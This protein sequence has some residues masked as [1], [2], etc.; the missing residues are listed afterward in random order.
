MI[1][2]IK[3]VLLFLT[4]TEKKKITCLVFGFIFSGVLEAFG[5][6]I[7]MPFVSIVNDPELLSSYPGVFAFFSWLGI[8]EH[9]STIIILALGILVLFSVKNLYLFFF[10]RF[11]YRFMHYNTANF[12]I[13]LLKQY[14]S[15]DYLY[16]LQKNSSQLLRNIKVEV[17]QVFTS[18]IGTSIIL[19]SE[20]VITFSIICVLLYLQ[21]IATITGGVILGAV[22]VVFYRFLRTKSRIYGEQRVIH[23]GETYKWITQSLNGIKELRILGTEQYFLNRCN[24]HHQKLARITVFQ[25]LVSQTPRLFME[26]LMVVTIMLMIVIL[27]LHGTTAMQILPTLALFAAAAFRLMPAVNRI[28]GAVISVRLATPGVELIYNELKDIRAKY[29]S[30]QIQATKERMSFT[31]EIQVKNLSFRYPD[32]RD[33][34]IDKISVAIPKNQSVGII[35]SS[36]AGKS[37]LLNLLLGLLSPSQGE[38][39]V[40][41]VSIAS[42]T[43]S[44]QNII[45]FVPQEIYLMDDSVKKNIAYGID[46][47]EIDEMQVWE[48][49]RM[50]QLDEYVMELPERLETS[51]GERGVRISG[52]Q[53]QRLGIA[54]ALYRNPEVLI[55][56]EATSALDTSTE[57]E[58]TKSIEQLANKKTIIIVA[59]RHTTIQNCDIIY[60]LEN[61]SIKKTSLFES[62]G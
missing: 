27:M 45:G 40:D 59:H 43:R 51:V 5:I 22:S 39:L 35:G 24:T 44:W 42:N 53:K 26:T 8:V 19:L 28:L 29:K 60:K 7:I 12:S 30:L 31:N 54:R 38:I 46:E 6:G 41:N 37:T 34:S 50:A 56:D 18:V 11:Q 1:S 16:H 14:L 3:K 47:K 55:F 62:A 23:E 4:E 36:G 17:P 61:G 48:A 15:V 52:G 58:I 32:A 9:N 13:R 20:I 33:H 21:P 10:M 57:K 2:V 49:L 25:Y